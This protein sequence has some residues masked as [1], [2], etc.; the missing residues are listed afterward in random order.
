MTILTKHLQIYLLMLLLNY[1]E[2]PM[3]N[4]N[5]CGIDKPK[6]QTKQE[7][8]QHFTKAHPVTIHKL[9]TGFIN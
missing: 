4:K 8:T 7:A 1:H 2:D 3:Y 9:P 5:R 6:A